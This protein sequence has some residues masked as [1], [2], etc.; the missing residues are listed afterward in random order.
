VASAHA[1]AWV[2][3]NTPGN[4]K[5]F[6][7]TLKVKS[8]GAADNFRAYVAFSLPAS[9]PARCVLTNATLRVF[10]G[11]WTPGRTLSAVAVDAPWTEAGVTWANQPAA[12]GGLAST[13]SG[14]GYREWDVTASIRPAVAGEPHHGFVIRDAVESALGAEQSFFS[15]EL[16]FPPQL[17]LHFAG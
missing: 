5:G 13:T 17:V 6:D 7:T 10:A 8:Q 15:R 16:N 14:A 2:E 3:Q 9:L 12:T 4:N 11:S 1:D